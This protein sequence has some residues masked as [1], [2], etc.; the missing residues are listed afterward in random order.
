M[1]AAD[2]RAKNNHSKGIFEKAVED[3]NEEF[4][5][6]LVNNG[7]CD[8]P[9]FKYTTTLEGA[10]GGGDGEVWWE[11]ANGDAEGN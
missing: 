8:D 10:E 4:I 3:E 11:N 5:E 7:Y 2:P 9:N 1:Y 6:Y